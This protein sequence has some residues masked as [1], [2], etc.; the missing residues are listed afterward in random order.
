MLLENQAVRCQLHEELSRQGDH[1]TDPLTHQPTNQ[2]ASPPSWPRPQTRSRR[3]RGT[4]CTPPAAGKE[5]RGEAGAAQCTAHRGAEALGCAWPLLLTGQH[6][7]RWGTPPAQRPLP[8]GCPRML[9]MLPGAPSHPA[10]HR[11]G[12]A[13]QHLEGNVGDLRRPKNTERVTSQCAKGIRLTA[14]PP[15]LAGSCCSRAAWRC[16]R[17]CTRTRRSPAARAKAAAGAAGAAVVATTAPAPAPPHPL[18]QQLQ[19]APGALVQE[20]EGHVKG[21]AT[22]DLQG[23]LRRRNKGGRGAREGGRSAIERGR[24]AVCCPGCAAMH[25]PCIPGPAKPPAV[26]AAAA[27]VAQ[28]EALSASPHPPTALARMW[29]VA[30]AALSMSCVRMRVASSDWCAS[31]IVVSVMSTPGGRRGSEV[32]M[33]WDAAAKRP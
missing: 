13:Q 18:A 31:R 25:V 32:R 29:A 10:T 11:V 27:A 8:R 17:L 1:P 21:G 2:P 23:A 22:P 4:T 19:A 7:W 26:A 14:P 24:Q 15:L 9:R 33:E 6:W 16:S 28:K 12:T 30:G 20:A 3:C 5:S